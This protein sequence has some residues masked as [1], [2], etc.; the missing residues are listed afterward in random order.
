MIKNASSSKFF[1]DSSGN[2][3]NKVYGQY[4]CLNYVP[5][6]TCRSCI[7]KGSK[8]VLELCPNK[9]EA[10]VWEESCQLRISDQKIF[11]HLFE[12]YK[13]QFNPKNIS[14]PDKFGSVVDETL[15]FLARKA[16]LESPRTYYATKEKEF[17]LGTNQTLYALVQCTQDLTADDCR[18]CLQE[19]IRHVKDCCNFSL[20]ARVLSP[21]CYLRYELYDFYKTNEPVKKSGKVMPKFFT[22]N[23]SSPHEV[24]SC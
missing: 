9:T 1:Q 12:I 24:C 6:S 3:P 14:D 13:H 19:A 7:V 5:N 21:S 23:C 15:S 2:S 22:C 17:E 20:G 10:I 11:G 16:V 18:K 4:M 8:D